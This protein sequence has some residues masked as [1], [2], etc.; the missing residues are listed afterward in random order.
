MKKVSLLLGTLGGALAGYILSNDKLRTELTKAKDTETA[1]KLLGTHLSRDGKKIAKEVQTFVT[2]ED[3]QKN[4]KKAK[5][6]AQ[7]KFTEAQ[8]GMETMMKKGGKKASSMMKTSFKSSKVGAEKKG[9][10]A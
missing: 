7:K 2:S 3:V 10:K 9:K 8:K 4:L 6:F 5:T 1:A